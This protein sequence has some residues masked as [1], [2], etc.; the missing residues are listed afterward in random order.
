MSFAQLII[1]K[2]SNITLRILS[3][4]GTAPPPPPFRIF[5]KI[6]AQMPIYC[7]LCPKTPQSWIFCTKTR[8]FVFKKLRSWGLPRQSRGTHLYRQFFRQKKRSYG[9]PPPP[10][11]PLQTKFL[12]LPLRLSEQY[13]DDHED[14]GLFNGHYQI[15]PIDVFDEQQAHD[16]WM[17]R[18][19]DVVTFSMCHAVNFPWI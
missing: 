7:V 14:W 13:S 19:L 10:P 2:R 4:R 8:I 17:I 15:M 11:P 6:F 18:Y 3:V 1:G 9:F 12:T 5:P 16:E